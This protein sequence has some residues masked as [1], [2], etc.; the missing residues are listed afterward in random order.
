MFK[1]LGLVRMEDWN[2][3]KYITMYLKSEVLPDETPGTRRRFWIDYNSASKTMAIWLMGLV[4]K[5][6]P[7]YERFIL[8]VVPLFLVRS[9]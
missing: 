4:E 8:P 7:V 5:R 9:V 1:A 6:R 3:A 2:A